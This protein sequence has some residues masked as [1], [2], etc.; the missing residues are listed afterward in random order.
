MAAI[1][2]IDNALPYF[3]QWVIPKTFCID[4]ETGIKKPN[5]FDAFTTIA[6]KKIVRMPVRH[7]QHH[8]I[9]KTGIYLPET[10]PVII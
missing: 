2:S 5:R 3:F 6:M 8:I 9:N 10:Q 1:V 4:N 7:S